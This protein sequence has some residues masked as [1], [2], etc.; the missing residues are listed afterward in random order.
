MRADR[1][2][3]DHAPRP[4][5]PHIA[6]VVMGG[7]ADFRDPDFSFGHVAGDALCVLPLALLGDP[8]GAAVAGK[9][10]LAAVPKI[11]VLIDDAAD[12][13]RIGRVTDAIQDDLSNR[14]LTRLRLAARFEIDPLSEAFLL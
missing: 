5:R 10:E 2:H 7:I 13:L 11:L 3:L 4:A 8:F 12:R 1:V 9:G 14:G 6:G